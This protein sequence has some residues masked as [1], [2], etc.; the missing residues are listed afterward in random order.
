MRHLADR[1]RVEPVKTD[2]NVREVAAS[3]DD[4]VTVLS[5][6]TDT[7][8]QPTRWALGRPAPTRGWHT[9]N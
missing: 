1:G 5:H 3:L 2:K 9:L 4:H 7:A 6:G 8:V